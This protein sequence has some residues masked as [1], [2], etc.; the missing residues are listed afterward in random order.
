MKLKLKGFSLIEL[1]IVIAIIGILAAIAVP[2]YQTYVNKSRFAEILSAGS[3]AE[4]AVSEYVTSAGGMSTNPDCT[5]VAF[6]YNTT[7]NV[8][9]LTIDASCAIT[10]VGGTNFG[11]SNNNPPTVTL[12]PSANTPDDGSIQWSCSTTPAGYSAAPST[13][14]ATTIGSA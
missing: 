14:P 4:T 2:S 9:S 13:C 3:A 11:T 8:A 6:T 1:M 10:I 7:G 12:T 5:N